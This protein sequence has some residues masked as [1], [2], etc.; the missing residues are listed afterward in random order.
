MLIRKLLRTGILLKLLSVG[1]PFLPACDY[2]TVFKR[3][4]TSPAEL[5]IVDEI[6]EEWRLRLMDISWFMRILNEFIARESNREDKV[7]GRFWER[8]FKS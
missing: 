8:R 5:K 7:I 6:I 3:W 1:M 4:C 2:F